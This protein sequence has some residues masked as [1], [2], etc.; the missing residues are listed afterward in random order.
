MGL[1]GLLWLLGQVGPPKG[2]GWQGWLFIGLMIG[3]PIAL[4]KILSRK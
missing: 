1:V 3:I 4:A 2:S